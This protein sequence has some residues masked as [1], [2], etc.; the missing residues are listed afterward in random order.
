VL[1]V[2]Q[3]RKMRPK[4]SIRTD[5]EVLVIAGKD[6]GKR[7]KVTHVI[8]EENRVIVEGVNMVKRHLR[9]QPGSLQAGII[10]KP[11]PLNRSNVML[12]CPNCGQPTR[13]GRGALPD[14]THVRVCKH[15]HEIIDKE[16]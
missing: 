8:P 9:R 11:A 4:L 3:K 14:G 5:D 7:G 1:K 16:R 15:C 2:A 13:E 6:R 10:D 12:V